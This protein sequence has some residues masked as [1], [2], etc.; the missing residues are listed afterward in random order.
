MSTR[1]QTDKKALFQERWDRIQAAMEAEDLD[2]LIVAARGAIGTFGNVFYLCG[3]TPLLRV[4][5]GVIHRTGEPVLFLP[6]HPDE[7]L[8]RERGIISDIRTSAEMEVVRGELSTPQAIVA[9]VK[10]RT[11]RRVGIVGLGAIVPVADHLLFQQELTGVELVDATGMY[12]GV[13]ELKTPGDLDYV[14]A[15]FA[16][17]QR[18]YDV[19]PGLIGPGERAQDVVAEIERVLRADTGSEALIFVDSAPYW[20]RRNTDTVFDVGHL[21]MVLVEVATVDGYF[22]EMGGLFSIGEPT[23]EAKVVS[24]ACYAA[25]RGVGDAIRPGA[26]I[27]D[28]TTKHEEIGRAA[29]LELALGLGH[30]VGVDHDL[31]TLYRTDET[32]FKTG[33]LISVHPYY[34]HPNKRVFGGVGDAFYVTDSGS[35]RMGRHDYSLRVV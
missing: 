30:G 18:A 21:V 25:L 32:T 2:T 35:E 8:A 34:W 9:E 4:T 24:D 23:P 16:L 13:K 3:Y 5:Y 20:V 33:Q 14:R 19:A 28:T 10:S 27:T 17:A 11:P 6:S 15:A 31:P 12:A 29:G 26:A 22:V 7:E 1:T